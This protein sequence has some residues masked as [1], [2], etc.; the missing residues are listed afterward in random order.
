[1]R[2]GS[3]FYFLGAA[4]FAVVLTAGTALAQANDQTYGEKIRE[5]TTDPRFV[6]ELVD[7]LPLS[8][9]VPSPLEY[10]GTII[11]APNILHNTA[12]IYGYMRAVADMSPRV[13]VR[14]IGKTEENRDMIEV[15]VAN[16]ATIA[17]LDRYRGYLNRL[18][19]P[20]G[21]SDSDVAA[22]LAEAKPIYY[23]TGG[24]H[25]PETG[26]PEML[27][28][29]AYRLAVE[30][31]P[32]IQGIR[33]NV[34]TIIV[35]V[36]EPDGRDRMVDSY[37]YGKAHR[38]VG[39]GLPYWGKY[40]AHDNNRDGYGL[41]LALTRNILASYL[42]WKPTVMH[43]LHESGNFLYI[44]TGSGPYNEHIDALAIDEWH[45]MAHE[46]VTQLTKFGM[47]GVWTH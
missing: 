5:Y 37:N 36:A 21:L 46:E 14:M 8:N 11:G 17:D 3:L 24:L 34:I 33:E 1:M 45:N 43:D 4:S 16:E 47:P 38:N 15:I 42:Y 26:P 44:S 20:R 35:P 40:V 23:F 13:T 6:S 2:C 27:M 30:D 12:Q 9:D 41:G 29:L 39:P 31:T 32:F 10:F 19:D 7:H 22:V 25:S 18:S 28:E